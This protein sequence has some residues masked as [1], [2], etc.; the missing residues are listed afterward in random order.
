MAVEHVLVK[1]LGIVDTLGCVSTIASD[2]V[3]SSESVWWLKVDVMSMRWCVRR[4]FRSLTH[5][6]TFSHTRIDWH[7]DTKPYVG[8]PCSDSAAAAGA[9]GKEGEQQQQGAWPFF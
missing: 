7:P 8:C 5:T 3:S 1:K 9:Q 6:N 2:K 4:R